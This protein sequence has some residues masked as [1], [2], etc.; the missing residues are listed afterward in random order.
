MIRQI[1]IPTFFL[2]FSAGET[3]WDDVITTL[4]TISQDSRNI[5]DLEWTDKC[6][7]IKENPLMCARLFDHRVKS[8]FADLLLSKAQPLGKVKDFFFRTEFQQRG[9]PHIHCLIWI[10]G[11][12]KLHEDSDE[13]VCTFI[14]KHITCQLPDSS[15]NPE[16]H[17]IVTAV[18]MH[19]KNH[20][21]SCR[22]HSTTCRFNFPRPPI[23]QTFIARQD[24]DQQEDTNDRD[25]KEPLTDKPTAKQILKDIWTLVSSDSHSNTTF[26]D[27]LKLAGSTYAEY[28]QSLEN[29]T[30]GNAIYHKRSLKDLWVN[31][32]NKYLLKAWNANMDI[33]YVTDVYSCVAY[34]LSYVSKAE[35][36]MSELLLNTKKEALQ[37]NE[38]AVSIMKKIGQVYMTNR[39]I[40]AQEAV[41]RVCSLKLKDS[42]RNVTFIPTGSNPL[43]MT[44]PINIIRSRKEED[45]NIWMSTVF[46]KYYGR[47]QLPEFDSMCL[48]DFCSN[49]Q[50]YPYSQ[51]P[52]SSKLTPSFELQ[53]HLGFAKQ[54][55]K[56]KENIIRYPR[57][58]PQKASEDFYMTLL[59]LY[60]P[61]RSSDIKPPE[62]L[63]YEDFVRH[64]TVKDG[65]KVSY[66]IRTNRQ[67]Y[68]QDTEKL[69]K[70]LEDIQS[71]KLN[72][73]AWA[74]IA[75]E[76]EAE[77][78]EIEMEKVIDTTEESEN[79]PEFEIFQN[80]SL[81]GISQATEFQTPKV[82]KEEIN[83]LTRQLNGKQ[84]E[85]FYEIRRWCIDVSL[86]KNPNPFHI[87][88]TG[89]AGTGKTHLVRCIYH[90]AS[91][92]LSKSASSPDAVSV[93]L[94]APTG[95]AAFNIQGV[96]V[97]SAFAIS[98][99]IKLPY[100]PLGESLVNSLRT[101]Y[102]S[103]RILVIDEISMVDHK[104]LSYIHGRL[105]QIMQSKK[106]FGNV[107]LLAVKAS[108]LYRDISSVMPDMWNHVFKIATL[109]EIMRQ[110]D[111][112]EFAFLLNRLRTHEK[113]QPI[114][115]ND[116]SILSSVSVSQTPEEVKYVLHIFPT[117]K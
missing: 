18:Q 115:S 107:A 29:I 97:H 68:E 27:I 63:K 67:K 43:K 65:T 19:S 24:P 17:E 53:N 103:L 80:E 8:L 22:K 106:Q 72:Q 56:G 104:L 69:E 1:G 47:P 33:Q 4:L 40:S 38:D 23:H 74:Q 6:K 59:Q 45:E 95:T 87:F 9:S 84:Q 79:L 88:L 51:K 98:K 101:K 86:Q 57:F 60:V 21:K 5:S 105:S 108:P 37:G 66:I 111:D 14:D 113:G 2:T 102:E 64:G 81:G 70:A 83:S 39:E 93:L 46:D 20:T 11:A 99:V 36:E 100:K 89:G 35:G 7:L 10:D 26:E 54:K 110:K 16:L 90:E 50:L 92:I 82:S 117:N 114:S 73:D 28:K 34:I 3:R 75:P 32:Y 71:G 91:R 76:A 42:S 15:D 52:N 41:Y 85:I 30:K 31:N 48:A 112:K 55:S 94:T 25:E 49:Y 13:D 109:T 58:N 77:R 116:L 62:F 96:T 12:P 78:L 44:L 61:H